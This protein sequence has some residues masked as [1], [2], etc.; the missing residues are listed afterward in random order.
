MVN[1]SSA[2]NQKISLSHATPNDSV[3]G[4]RPV[5]TSAVPEAKRQNTLHHLAPSSSSSLNSPSSASTKEHV[6]HAPHRSNIA[7]LIDSVNS[8]SFPF[9][10]ST[11]TPDQQ[12]PPVKTSQSSVDAPSPK[13]SPSDTENDPL[14]S[15]TSNPRP[16]ADAQLTPFSPPHSLS[17]SFDRSLNPAYY[18]PYRQPNGP[19]WVEGRDSLPSLDIQLRLADIF[20]IYAHGQPYVLFHRDSFIASLRAQ[21]LP[22]IL[23]LSMCS[24]AIRFWQ[25]DEYDKNAL[26]QHCFSKASS[27]AMSNFDRLDL[28]YVA[29]FIMLSYISVAD[30]KYWMYT[31]LAIRMSVAL[32]PNKC[33]DLPYYDSPE[34]PLPSE[35]RGQLIRRLFWDCFMLDR[36]NSLYCNS[37]F[38][39]LED[40][41]VPLPMRESLFM[42]NTRAVTETIYG[43]PGT[44]DMPSA[45]KPADANSF[46]VLNQH[47]QNNMGVLAYMIRMVSIW[48]RVVRCLKAYGSK[49]Q[50]NPR[51]F[52]HMSGALQ[53][54]DQELYEWEKS[55]P[56]RLRYTRQSLLSYHMKGQ[57]GPF[58]CM[59][60]IYLQVHLY[61]HRYA[62]S[63]SPLFHRRVPSP[64]QSFEKQSVLLATF[65]A[66][67]IARILHDCV[68]L[69]ISLAA[70]FTAYSAY[71][72]GTVM[73]FHVSN[74]DNSSQATIATSNLPKVK[75]HLQAT[76]RYWPTIAEYSNALES[77]SKLVSRSPAT[78]TKVVSSVPN[79]ANNQGRYA[80]PRQGPALSTV[81]NNVP[82]KPVPLSAN[83]PYTATSSSTKGST[84]A[85][86]AYD[87]QI[88]RPVPAPGVASSGSPQGLAF[89]NRISLIPNAVNLV[90]QPPP[91]PP[92]FSSFPAANAT[93]SMIKEYAKK[94]DIDPDL[95]RV[96]SLCDWFKNPVDELALNKPL[97]LDS[98]DEQEKA[99]ID[100]GRHNTALN[101]WKYGM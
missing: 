3:L 37:Q 14:H 58:A 38:L 87:T 9:S 16:N 7:S 36:L 51:P 12:L 89:E 1:D 67:A 35:I 11:S 42:Y 86:L 69:S 24:I 23:V 92:A 97:Q 53:P 59:H 20:F 73:L 5:E 15:H 28:V 84:L 4:K 94:V 93:A 57:G 60:L 76:K 80:A 21:R 75:R 47:A 81:P 26:L 32:H 62:A 88:S 22:P 83:I 34:N 43:R 96:V 46:Q 41:H 65:C 98:S 78:A 25:T 30:D 52:W 61:I 85:D 54:L 71:M 55:L 45:S 49:K 68:E 100:I 72:A 79:A 39:N 18:A 10:P 95:V 90:S 91:P 17:P 99:A 2:A 56:Q 29:C 44:A 70:P 8:S 74:P 101:L 48:G 6:N 31:G 82:I 27:I 66:N 63:V 19:L 13:V 64:P 33:F 50:I 40:I 77:L